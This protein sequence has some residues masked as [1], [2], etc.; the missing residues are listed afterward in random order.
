LY[1]LTIKSLH[2]SVAISEERF[3][4]FRKV[5]E[6]KHQTQYQRMIRRLLDAYIDAQDQCPAAGQPKRTTGKRTAA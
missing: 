1:G 4:C 3:Y 2:V 5:E 6:S